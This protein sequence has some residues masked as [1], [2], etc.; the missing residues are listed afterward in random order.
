MNE[1]AA[2]SQDVI[3]LNSSLS[4]LRGSNRTDADWKRMEGQHK[5]GFIIPHRHH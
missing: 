4:A 2:L 5:V 1:K 3:D